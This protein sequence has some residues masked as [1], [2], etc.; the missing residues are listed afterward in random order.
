M[1]P[2]SAAYC[3][4]QLGELWAAASESVTSFA[5]KDFDTSCYVVYLV[6]ASASKPTAFL[7]AKAPL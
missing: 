3:S 5:E 2:A 6:Q 1:G 4:H 7:A